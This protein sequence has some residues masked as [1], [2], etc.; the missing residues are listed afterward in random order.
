MAVRTWALLTL[1]GGCDYVHR[2]IPGI[3]DTTLRRAHDEWL[4]ASPAN[5]P[6]L[7]ITN[8]D[9][10]TSHKGSTYGFSSEA[11]IRF[12]LFALDR[13][14]AT[15]GTESGDAAFGV[16]AFT[17]FVEALWT[18]RYFECSVDVSEGRPDAL[19]PDPLE[20]TASGASR[21]GFCLGGP[22]TKDEPVVM[23]AQSVPAFLSDYFA[24]NGDPY[25]MER[26]TFVSVASGVVGGDGSGD[27]DDDDDEP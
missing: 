14:T 21:W 3:T 24:P 27:D 19:V 4:T 5:R 13:D 8:R 10:A 1:M 12:M 2:W 26:P 23:F 6:I 18:L 11:V 15:F 17:Q 22:C 9:R 20:R 25:P 7:R 16:H